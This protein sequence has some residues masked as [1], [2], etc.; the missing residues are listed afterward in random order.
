MANT[1]ETFTY[2]TVDNLE[3]PLDVYLPADAK[4]VPIL[5]WF[6]GGGLLQGHRARLAGHMQ[7]SASKYNHA[8]VSADYRLAPQVGIH[9]IFE[10]IR[11]SVAFVRDPNGLSKHLGA[12]VVDT[13]RLA[14]SGSSAG[15]Y[16][17]LLAGL[18]VEPKPNVILAIY[19]ITGP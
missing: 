18:Y 3:I 8:V 14:V 6:H 10:D 16:L 15:G 17:A 19:P 4:N 13:S 9:E 1:P 12:G 5:L 2:K 7:R 11:D